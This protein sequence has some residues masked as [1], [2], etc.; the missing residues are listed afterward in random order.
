MLDAIR[1]VAKKTK[2]GRLRLK[3]FLTVTNIQPADV[4]RHFASWNGAI[5]AAGLDYSGQRRFIESDEL[6]K[7]W[8]AMTRELQRPPS[9][10][11]YNARGKYSTSALER[12]FG[13]LCNIPQVFRSFAEGKE[14]WADVVKLCPPSSRLRRGG[15][16]PA[17]LPRRMR[18]LSS[19]GRPRE[20]RPSFGDPVN[21]APGLL[22][23]PM[24]E[25]GVIFIFGMLAERLGFH[26]R[27]IRPTFPDCIAMR[28]TG[29]TAWQEQ[30]IEF[31]YESKNFKEHGHS[32][33]G[34]DVI[35]CWVHNWEECPPNLEVIALSEEL[36]RL[37][38]VSAPSLSPEREDEQPAGYHETARAPDS[39]SV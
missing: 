7:D 25:S 33:D 35:V 28:W 14:E 17:Q 2:G 10:S 30:T 8:G 15:R 18:H 29:K 9:A 16:R 4:F 22:N 12:R 13:S 38:E 1:S 5:A 37:R 11:V 6:L 21:N 26:I 20:D 34:C 24:N 39:G 23:A 27:A 31:E 36:E 3:R 32:P 19:P